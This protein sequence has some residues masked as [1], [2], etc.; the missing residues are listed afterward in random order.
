L[1]RCLH[2]TV[3]RCELHIFVDASQEA[4]GAVAYLR[5]VDHNHVKVSLVAAKSKVAPLQAVSVPRLE[6]MAAVLGTRLVESVLVAMEMDVK[7]VRM[8]SDSKNVLWWLLRQ[9][10]IFKPFVANRVAAIQQ[11]VRV[12]QWRHV[13]TKLNPADFLSRGQNVHDFKENRLWWYGPEFLG[14]DETE[15][16]AQ[17]S[18]TAPKKPEVR[19]SAQEEA[20]QQSTTLVATVETD[21]CR[22]NPRRFSSFLRLQR[23]T[24]WAWHF[25]RNCQARR[26]GRARGEL[27]VDELLDAEE[28]LVKQAQS[29]E[30]GPSAASLAA[31]KCL[32]PIQDTTGVW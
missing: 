23:V 2:Q 30:F 15:W 6:L 16:P 3:D 27:T 14:Q 18:P 5:A 32:N 12:E 10:R 13:P 31:L 21:D 25:I 4:Y 22:L 1:R 8:W 11:V 28:R 20:G 19:R 17:K 26:D 7:D 24:A 29:E 9:S